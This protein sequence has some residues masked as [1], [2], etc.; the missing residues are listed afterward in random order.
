LFVSSSQD[1]AGRTFLELATAL[2]CRKTAR[3]LGG[4]DARQSSMSCD[5]IEALTESMS[6]VCPMEVDLFVPSA[7]P[8]EGNPKK[9]LKCVFH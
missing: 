8:E 2:H 1:D 3:V 9:L 7:G 4:D 6:P 5:Q